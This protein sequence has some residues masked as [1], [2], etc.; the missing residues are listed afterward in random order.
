MYN[1]LSQAP[2]LIQIPA[3]APADVLAAADVQAPRHRRNVRH[4]HSKHDTSL[5][6]L[7]LP[8]RH[9]Y[10]TF[11]KHNPCTCIP[12]QASA[13]PAAPSQVTERRQRRKVRFHIMKYTH[14]AHG[15]SNSCHAYIKI[16]HITDFAQEGRRVVI[17]APAQIQVPAE[18]PAGVLATVPSS[19]TRK[20]HKVRIQTF[21]L[22]I[23]IHL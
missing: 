21:N 1:I 17:P 23:H 12:Q 15:S 16:Q 18:A 14:S 3:P 8:Q 7:A 9:Y 11:M 2:N 20:G 22:S 4:H 13:A 5:C 19:A 6:L 10:I